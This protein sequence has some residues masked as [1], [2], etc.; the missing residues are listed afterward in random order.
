MIS[1]SQNGAI[2]DRRTGKPGVEPDPGHAAF[3]GNLQFALPAFFLAGAP[4]LALRG[5]A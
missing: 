1:I 2:Y 5:R 4:R 3:P